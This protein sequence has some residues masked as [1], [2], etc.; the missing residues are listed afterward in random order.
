MF[1]DEFNTMA[2]ALQSQVFSVALIWL[3]LGPAS[4]TTAVA[5]GAPVHTSPMQHR[6]TTLT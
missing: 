5:P 6:F 1:P 3:D 4:L 2:G